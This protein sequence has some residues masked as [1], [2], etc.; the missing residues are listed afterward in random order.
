MRTS[1][2]PGLLRIFRY[3]SNVAVI[4][5]AIL[6]GYSIVSTGWN[7]PLQVQMLVNL[8]VYMGLTVYLTLTGLERRLKQ[9]Y[10]PVG[11]GIAMIIP[12]I[13]N[14]IYLFDPNQANINN[15]ISRSWLWLPVLLIPVVL[16]AWQYSFT[17]VLA[18]TIF[19]NGLELIVL[20]VVVDEVSIETLPLLGVPLIRAFA[21]GIVGNI[22]CNLIDTQR[23]QRRKLIQANIRMGQYAN[24]LEHL[25][26][27]RER[28]RLAGEVHDILAHT[29]SGLAVNLEAI[30]TMI[31]PS[32]KEVGSMLEHSLKTTRNGLDETRRALKALRAQPLEELG[33]RAA[34]A[35]LTQTAASRAGILIELSA[36]EDLP[37]LLPDV[38]QSIYRITQEALENIVRH[39]NATTANVE[40][41]FPQNRVEL[42]VIDN[43]FGFDP[44]G[45]KS[46]ERF[47]LHGMMQRAA[48]VGADLEVESQPGMGSRIHFSWEQYLDQG[49]DM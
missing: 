42:W 18:Y 45:V 13:S 10:L 21:F 44:N 4:Y 24:T 41:S 34:L 17:P 3:F 2:E 49:T 26:T 19:T 39:A 40:L 7:W 36:P 11:L 31:D 16:I 28:N 35:S 23:L 27:S 48:A 33:L 43:G 29:L 38:E 12:V 47:G 37:T 14:F 6:W 22:V 20:L 9:F 5:F 32:Q 1:I 46:K 25:A 30:S 15:I 8:L